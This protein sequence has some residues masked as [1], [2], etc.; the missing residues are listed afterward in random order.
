V[1]T[2]TIDL[3][4]GRTISVPIGWYPRLAHG[5]PSERANF[6]ISRAGY[7]THWPELDEDIGVEGLLLGYK[8]RESA[9]YFAKW[10]EHRKQQSLRC[11]SRVRV[12]CELE[13]WCNMSSDL[14]PDTDRY[15]Q[16]FAFVD[17]LCEFLQTRAYIWGGWIPDIYSGEVLRSHSDAECL[18]VNLYR[19]R[20]QIQRVFDVLGW[21]TR[22]LE[23]GDLKIMK[24]GL[25]LQLG[26]LEIHEKSAE[27][28]HNGREG[29][30]AFSSSWL[31]DQTISFQNR[32]IHAVLPEFQYVLKLRP[33]L[34][35]PEWRH[36]D[37]DISDI[38][39]LRTLLKDT[40][41]P[42]LETRI[43]NV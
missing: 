30:I 11:T 5:T 31:N 34:M 9:T 18:V 25:K 21:Q 2:L 3:E 16:L 10:L 20:E 15:I 1:D 29:R 12:P 39:V 38:E 43:F 7:G 41:L 26:H 22:I 35:N 4:D 40:D 36:R 14:F 17:S 27:W 19:C 42:A 8:S 37:K 28:F 24:D 32:Y 6:Q 23:N 33:K 13:R